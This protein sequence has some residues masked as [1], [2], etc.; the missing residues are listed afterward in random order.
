MFWGLQP[1]TPCSGAF[2]NSGRG[3]ENGRLEGVEIS[4]LRASDLYRGN[5]HG[6]AGMV[7]GCGRHSVNED[8]GEAVL[9]AQEGILEKTAGEGG[10]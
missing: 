8:S 3:R 4:G 7:K 5:R 6:R 1:K 10:G 2:G 9:E